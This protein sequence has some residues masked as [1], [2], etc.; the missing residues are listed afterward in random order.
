VLCP[1]TAGWSD[2]FGGGL[3]TAAVAETAD[4]A[5]ELEAGDVCW[6]FV[7]GYDGLVSDYELWLE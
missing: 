5:F 3:A 1:R 6:I 2:L 4:A 7:V